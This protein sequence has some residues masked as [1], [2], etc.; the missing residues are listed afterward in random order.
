MLPI[1]KQLEEKNLP[2]EIDHMVWNDRMDLVAYS[3]T[4]GEVALHRL[5]WARA[6][7]LSPPS[8]NVNVECITFRPDGNVLAIAYDNGDIWIISIENKAVCK[9]I[10]TKK[11]ISYMSW[12][13]EKS[14]HK[15]KSQDKPLYSS[16]DEHNNY[17][18]YID[19]SSIYLAAPPLMYAEDNIRSPKKRQR[20]SLLH[21][22]YDLNILAVGTKDGEVT[23]HVFGE[24]P[25]VVLNMKDYL[26]VR[27]SVENILFTEDLSKLSVIVKDEKCNIK[28]I[29]INSEIIKSKTKEIYSVAHKCVQL[30]YLLEVIRGSIRNMKESWESILI[31]MDNKLSKYAS[32]CPEGGLAAEFMDLLMFGKYSQNM[33]EFLLHDLTKKGL[34]KFGEGIEVSYS[35]MQ[36]LLLKYVTKYG[37]CITYHLA[38]LRGMVRMRHMYNFID[39]CEGTIT[40]AIKSTGAFLIKAGEMHQTINQS[41]VNYKSFFRWLYRAMMVLLEEVEPPELQAMT[42]QELVLIAEFFQNFDNIE[43]NGK[44]FMMEKLGQYLSDDS[45]TMPSKMEENEWSAF[46]AEN[47]CFKYDSIILDHNKDFSLIQQFSKLENSLSSVFFT[48]KNMHKHFMKFDVFNCVNSPEELKI[49]SVNREESIIYFFPKSK[50]EIILLQINSDGDTRSCDFNFIEYGEPNIT[51]EISDIK[52]YS[53]SIISLLLRDVANRT[54]LMYQFPIDAALYFT[55]EIN[56]LTQSLCNNPSPLLVNGTYLNPKIYK[57]VQM[58]GSQLAVSGSRKVGIVL[59]ANRH[60]VKLFEMECEEEDDDDEDADISM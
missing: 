17:M 3:T 33:Q 43:G 42:Q 46:L 59:S 58:M 40:E 5:T 26:G 55:R 51:Y 2:Y 37:Q 27:C 10:A 49:T 14:K 7:I 52:V 1:I 20:P 22:Q 57:D 39:I 18:E 25:F 44:G 13:Q 11:K 30:T 24:H 31:E 60:K 53:T 35:T 29:L 45:L 16:G 34:E 32:K 38:E 23:L 12:V 8:K 9:F 15:N 4:K 36:E 48:S 21:E 54:S 56:V 47:N 28:I 19:L 50:H 41:I 6:W